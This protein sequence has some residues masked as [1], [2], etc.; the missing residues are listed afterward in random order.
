MALDITQRLTLTQAL[1][2]LVVVIASS[3]AVYHLTVSSLE[4]ESEKAAESEA[5]R[6]SQEIFAQLGKGILVKSK[7]D[8]LPFETVHAR[9]VHWAVAR[10]SGVVIVGKGLFAKDQE[11]FRE[12]SL[13]TARLKLDDDRVFQI[14]GLPFPKGRSED[15][16]D[17]PRPVR[18]T[19]LRNRPRGRYLRTKREIEEGA[20][21]YEVRLL[22][23][24]TV[25]D[26]EVRVDGS[27]VE[28]EVHELP[29]VLSPEFMASV[30]DVHDGEEYPIV[31]WRGHD[32]ELL[33]VVEQGD[34]SGQRIITNRYGERYEVASDGRLIGPTDDTAIRL[35]VATDVTNDQRAADALLAGLLFGAPIVW[36]LVV[37][38]GWFVTRRALSPV[39]RILDAA[40]RIEPSHLDVRLPCGTVRDELYM[41]SETINRMLD[42]LEEGFRRERRFTGDASHELRGPLTKIMA[43]IGVALSRPRESDEYR[44]S[45]DRCH[46]YA[47][48]LKTI[49]ESL[50]LLSRLDREH[51]LPSPVRVDVDAVLLDTVGSLQELERGRVSLELSSGEAPT[52]VVGHDELIRVL[53]RN[54]LENA[55]RYS[56]RD[57]LVTVRTRR[58]G[59]QVTIEI[60]DRGPGLPPDR[61]ERVFDRFYR[62]DESRTRETGG[63]GL[64]LSICRSIARAHHGDIELVA[65]PTGGTV[66]RASLPLESDA[67]PAELDS[68]AAA[69]KK[70]QSPIER[71]PVSPT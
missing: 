13:G 55:L 66:A 31:G 51:T 45:L 26:L 38:I 56:P 28:E 20:L 2:T 4:G 61:R 58:D 6:A 65:S 63:V 29:E 16:E 15:F 46:E 8:S 19:V 59:S 30:L 57:E 47:E 41:I 14:V 70:R 48:S 7:G 32:F 23:E 44:E 27:I 12:A 39:R 68:D 67:S 43:E 62:V 17:L 71:R 34:G 11:R 52:I 25:Y 42:R 1:L 49:V 21:L 64:G 24:G 22:E 10:G 60:E 50:L 37:A 33:A 54:L 53:V 69:S 40:N 3:I 18:E 9:T 36:A 5:Y 35:L